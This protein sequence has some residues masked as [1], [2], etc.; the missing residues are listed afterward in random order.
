MNLLISQV[1]HNSNPDLNSLQNLFLEE[2]VYINNGTLLRDEKEWN[3]ASCNNVDR[4]G[5]YYAKWSKPEKGTM[6]SLIYGI[7]ET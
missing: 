5:V 2:V 6:F 1:V 3:L 4:T 7:L